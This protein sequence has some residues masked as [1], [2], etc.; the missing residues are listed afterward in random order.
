MPLREVYIAVVM[1][2]TRREISPIDVAPNGIPLGAK[3]IGKVKSI[4][5]S[6]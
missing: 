6:Y 2:H 5:D 4:S 1:L 3:P